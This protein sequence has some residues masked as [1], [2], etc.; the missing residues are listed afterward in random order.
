MS[1][2]EPTVSLRSAR[3]TPL[4]PGDA[5]EEFGTARRCHTAGCES[6]LSRYNPSVTCSVHSGWRTTPQTRRRR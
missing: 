3:M 2:I 5:V 6:Q 1:L 4:A